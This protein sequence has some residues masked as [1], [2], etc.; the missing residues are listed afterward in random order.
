M[1]YFLNLIF[2]ALVIKTW[3]KAKNKVGELEANANA[4]TNFGYTS[5][6]MKMCQYGEHI[7]NTENR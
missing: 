7:A 5:L 4:Q 1:K 3:Q 6:G 2:A